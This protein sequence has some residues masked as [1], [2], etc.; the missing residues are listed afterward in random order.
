MGDFEVA[1]ISGQKVTWKRQAG[2]VTIDT[3]ALKKEC[4]EIY[5]KYKKVGKDFRVFKA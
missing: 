2:R 3:K 5:E 1:E 4:F